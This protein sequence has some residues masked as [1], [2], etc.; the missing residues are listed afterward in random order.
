[1]TRLPE[2]PRKMLAGLKLYGRKPRSAAASTSGARDADPSGAGRRPRVHAPRVWHVGGAAEE[3][4]PAHD[5]CGGERDEEGG[6]GSGPDHAASARSGASRGCEPL[7]AVQAAACI[8]V[9]V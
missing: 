6:G 8:A 9:A 1:M 7:L 5:G 2:S 3:R 4:Q